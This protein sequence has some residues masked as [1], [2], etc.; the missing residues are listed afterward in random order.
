LECQK[1]IYEKLVNYPFSIF[2]TIPAKFIGDY[3]V[4]NVCEFEAIFKKA[5]TLN[6]GPIGGVV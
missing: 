6:Q 5:F 2:S 4:E 1:Q 3:V